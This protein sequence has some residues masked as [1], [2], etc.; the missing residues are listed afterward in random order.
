MPDFIARAYRDARAKA[1]NETD[2]PIATFPETPTPKFERA[3][4][5]ALAEANST[6]GRSIRGPG[7]LR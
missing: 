1:S 4:S 3:L 7:V 5:A 2:L 6:P